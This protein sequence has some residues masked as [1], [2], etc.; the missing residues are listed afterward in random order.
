MATAQAERQ[1]LDRAVWGAEG[2]GHEARR[3]AGLEVG[4]RGEESGTRG[5]TSQRSGQ[6]CSP[7]ASHRG[8]PAGPRAPRETVLGPCAVSLWSGSLP[9]SHTL[10]KASFFFFFFFSVFARP[11][12]NRVTASLSPWRQT[13]LI[14]EE[15]PSSLPSSFF[16][17]WPDISG[18]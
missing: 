11:S 2:V 16:T 7:C 10:R 17:D 15:P 8:L 14:R 4:V 5:C 13:K 12:V 1:R 9:W 18:A 3:E 6:V